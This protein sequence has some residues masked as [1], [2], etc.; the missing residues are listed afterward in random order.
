MEQ[1]AENAKMMDGVDSD[2]E[3]SDGVT[4]KD[5][6]SSL[7]EVR[8]KKAIYKQRHRLKGKLVHSQ[9]KANVEDAIDHFESIGL[10]VN[11]ESLRSR[12]KTRRS[13]AD[14]EGA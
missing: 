9:K 13:I 2:E 5:L 6:K 10:N 1:E 12:S 14:L 3:N 7:A 4:M 8:S 11:R